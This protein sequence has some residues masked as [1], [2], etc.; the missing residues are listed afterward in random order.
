MG[1]RYSAVQEQTRQWSRVIEEGAINYR[2][3]RPQQSN[4]PSQRVHWRL[5]VRVELWHLVQG[6]ANFICP[7]SVN[8]VP[9]GALMGRLGLLCRSPSKNLELT[10]FSKYIPCKLYFLVRFFLDVKLFKR[11]KSCQVQV[12]NYISSELHSYLGQL[13]WGCLSISIW[14][15]INQGP[16]L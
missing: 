15:I 10:L 3:E 6:S 13:V 11:L 5:T 9:N 14:N 4:C 12:S 16:N 1:K 8:W 7:S 2:V